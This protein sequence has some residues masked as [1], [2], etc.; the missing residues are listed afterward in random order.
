MWK[1]PTLVTYQ[2]L[3]WIITGCLRNLLDVLCPTVL[4]FKIV[5][6]FE[7][8]PANSEVSNH[9]RTYGNYHQHI[10]PPRK[11]PLTDD[12]NGWLLLPV[13]WLE[14]PGLRRW[15]HKEETEFS[16]GA[17]NSEGPRRD[18][19]QRTDN[20]HAHTHTQGWLT[21]AESLELSTHTHTHTERKREREEVCSLM[22]SAVF[23]YLSPHHLD[24]NLPVN[25]KSLSHLVYA[26]ALKIQTP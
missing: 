9:W 4:F 21:A 22:S 12:Q 10:I 18:F 25:P 14:F 2:K 5:K 26:N 6:L 16:A 24:L 17:S 1:I 15:C 23:G 7:R 3:L 13:T 8:V 11:D 19:E 20:T